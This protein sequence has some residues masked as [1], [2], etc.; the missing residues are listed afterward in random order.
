VVYR[1]HP[2]SPRAGGQHAHRTHAHTRTHARALSLVCHTQ[3][4]T[5]THSLALARTR[6]YTHIHTHGELGGGPH[7]HA[8]PKKAPGKGPTRNS[9]TRT[10]AHHPVP[11]AHYASHPDTHTHWWHRHSIDECVQVGHGRADLLVDGAVV[12]EVRFD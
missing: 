2:V 7:H 6:T 1:G 10:D 8:H 12:V 5:L 3:T 11:S 4:H 9:C